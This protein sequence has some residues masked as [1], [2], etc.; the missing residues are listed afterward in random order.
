MTALAL[1]YAS[2]DSPGNVGAQ[3]GGQPTSVTTVGL[4]NAG[5][6]YRVLVADDQPDVL[7]ALRL[8]LKVQG[9]EAISANSPEGVL[10]ALEEQDF[11]VLLMDL[12]YTR[13]TTSG[14]EGLDLLERLKAMDQ[15][16]PVVV[17]T[18]WGSIELAVEAMRRGAR[19]FVPKPWE[20]QRLVATLREHAAA[21]RAPV[22]VELNGAASRAADEIRIAGQ[23][24]RKLFPHKTPPLRT[25]EYS[26]YCRQAGPVGGDYYDF[27]DLGPGRL[28]LVLADISG[29]GVAAA[30]LMANL[31]ASLRSRSTQAWDDL[32][33]VIQSV[34]QLFCEST[35]RERYATLFF[36]CYDDD[37]RMLRYVNCGHYPPVVVRAG[38]GVA[39]LD[40]TATVLG[41]FDRIEVAVGQ[42]QMTPGDLLAI[43]SDGVVE[44]RGRDGEEF[45]EER[46]VRMLRR[47]QERE[48]SAI[49][50]GLSD[51]LMSYAAFGQ[52][53]D[54]TLVVARAV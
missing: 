47:N 39:R 51:S 13:D 52:E 18:A 6:A 2:A 10:R 25:L 53:D 20:N 22:S 29:K 34:N 8:L 7:A 12:N 14:K 32:P 11:D 28:G 36:G 1:P 41:L 30:L 50:P 5:R 23:V 54:L 45:G 26:A 37:R 17:M 42:A 3:H 27:L 43:F 44:A 4:D 48:I 38:G 19:D 31:Q 35:E 49:P 24:Q 40:S 33:G 15:A 16:P 46:L 9:F 21:R